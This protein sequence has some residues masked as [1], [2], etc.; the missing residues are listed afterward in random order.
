LSASEVSRGTRWGEAH[1][2]PPREGGREGPPLNE[3]STALKLA[4]SIASGTLF[5]LSCASFD[6]WPL[7]WIAGVPLLWVTQH[8][9]VKRPWVWGLVGGTVANGGGF[10]WL[11]GFMGRFGHLPLVASIPIFLLMVTYQ[12]ITFSL[13]AQLTR[14][15]SDRKALP[16][17][18]LA[19]ICWVAVELCVP[20]VFPWY[21]AITQAWVPPVVQIAELTGPLG[22]SFLLVLSNAAIYELMRARFD[23]QPS[24]WR[25][26]GAAI[27]AIGLCI[28][29][30][31]VRMHQ[32][33]SK[34][35][36]APKLKVGVVQANIGIQE[37]WRPELSA[38]Q[39]AVHQQQSAE[40]ERRGAELIVWPESSYPGPFLR[41]QTR[42][43]PEDSPRRARRGF[44]RPVL[45]G[46][47]TL[48]RATRYP[49]NTALL[50]DADGNIAGSFDKNILMVFGEYIPF[51]EQMK[52]IKRMIPAT[53]NFARGT[54][55]TTFPL[56]WERDG[57]KH[58][59]KLAPMICYEDIFPSFGRRVAKLGPNLLVNITNDAW[60]G[61]T[62]EPWEHMALSVY[63]AVELRLDLVRAVNTG[64]STVITASGR[65]QAKT[66]GVDPDEGQAEGKPQP[67]PMTLLEDVAIL[68]AA[69]LYATLGEWF[70]ALCLLIVVV[71][72]VRARAQGGSPLELAPIA[73][74]LG[75]LC[76]VLLLGSAIA[77][78][79][80][81]IGIGAR[82]IAHMAVPGVDAAEVFRIGVWLVPLTALGSFLVGVIVRR[83]GG[84]TAEIVVA[85]LLVLAVPALVLGTLEGEQAG[86][87]IAALVAVSVG[88]LGKRLASKRI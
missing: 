84:D 69:T 82:L 35:A 38:E 78:G 58:S 70:G 39:L 61:N 81:G 75:T 33:D 72:G 67:P 12:G 17:T 66:K 26:F 74:G 63:R 42:D 60:F 54:D 3:L 20:Y 87:V 31:A 10:Y 1:A 4:L 29:F 43:W 7:C 51:Y 76:G 32:I 44:T 88:L 5:F 77:G 59:A 55:V 52:F 19:P 49:Y 73:I 85:I 86:L 14:R 83:R 15:L 79:G 13:F 64:V 6:I 30:G 65:V 16:L 21:L 25:R 9:S 2:A 37:K 36:A 45:F 46:A 28:A 8:P 40:L 57:Q 53:S 80:E 22:V 68:D 23:R 48:S 62:S 24:P 47:L 50:I 27:G 11:V 41:D 18:L 56:E 34:R 71:L